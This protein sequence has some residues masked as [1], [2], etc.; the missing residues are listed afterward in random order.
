MGQ[1]F[2]C[3]RNIHLQMTGSSGIARCILLL[4]CLAA[5]VFGGRSKKA[6]ASEGSWQAKTAVQQAAAPAANAQ[7]PITVPAPYGRHTDDLDGMLKR[8]NIRALVVPNPIAFFYDK[9]QPMGVT[10]EALYA[11]QQFVNARRRRGA[12]PILVT[13]IP[14]RPDQLEAALLQGVGDVIAYGVVVTPERQREAGFTTPIMTGVS[15]V[16]VSG[17]NFGSVSSVEDLAGKQV[18]V[19]PLAASYESLKQINSKLHGEGKPPIVIK[20]AAE[21]LTEDDIIQMVNA[22]IVPATVASSTRAKL[23]SQVLPHLI[24]HKDAVIASNE[25][26]AWVVRKNNPQLQ[27]LLDEFIAPRAVGTSFGN[28]VLRRYLQN[29][30][31]ITN[32]TSAEEMKKFDALSDIFKKYAGQYNF[33]YLMIMAQGYQE[34]RLDQNTRFRDAIGIMQVNPKLAAASPINVHDVNITSNNIEAGVKML[35]QI[36]DQYFN[37]PGIDPLDKTLMVFASYNAGPNRIAELRQKAREQGLDPDKWFD[38]VELTVAQNVGQ[39]TVNYVNNIYKYYI[40]YKL[41]LAERSTTPGS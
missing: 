15:Q 12:L 26:L 20:E 5:F 25:Q 34:S 36:E 3:W 37:D 21:H 31:W 14:V 2:A 13:F 35:R 7:A 23:W 6:T 9:G 11:F 32:S 28:T 29:T 8:Q 24:V 39:V 16:I 22:G 18:Y 1:C 17:P 33:S 38:N 10:Y 27:R 41:V 40:A 30:K 4:G 19:N